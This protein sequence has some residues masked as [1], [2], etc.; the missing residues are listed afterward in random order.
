M[1]AFVVA[2]AWT[3]GRALRGAAAQGPPIPPKPDRF[4]VSAWASPA[5]SS[6]N[7]AYFPEH[8][9]YIIDT[10]EGKVWGVLGT[11]QPKYLGQ[12]KDQR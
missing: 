12:V 8:G 11:E 4:Q 1:V 10:R 7:N 6:G 2:F 5:A 3:D 9:A